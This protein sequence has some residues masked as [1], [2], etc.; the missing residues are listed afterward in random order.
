MAI[1]STPD[2]KV[3]DSNPNYMVDQVLKHKLISRLAVTFGSF[4]RKRAKKG[5]I[6]ENLGGNAQNLKIFGKTAAAC[7]RLSYA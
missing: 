5:K 2:P 6:F 7:V 1:A 4:L 3:L